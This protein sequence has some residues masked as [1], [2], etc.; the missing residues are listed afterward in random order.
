MP[1]VPPEIRTRFAGEKAGAKGCEDFVH[2]RLLKSVG[3]GKR[4]KVVVERL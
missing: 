4:V 1:L 2:G 3:D